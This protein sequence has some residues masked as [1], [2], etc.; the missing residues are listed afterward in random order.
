MGPAQAKKFVLFGEKLAA[1][2][3]AAQGFADEIAAD[4]EALA[5]ARE[6]ATRVAKLPPN[7]V[8]MT[9]QSV[10]AA[11]NALHAATTFM[12]RDQF[13]LAASSEDYREAI[14]AFLEK[15]PPRFT[16]R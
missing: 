10:N 9:K 14:A 7:A 6:L 8:R 11:A 15:R 2:D 4:G 13:L 1:Q 12:D 3:A 16:G 5:K